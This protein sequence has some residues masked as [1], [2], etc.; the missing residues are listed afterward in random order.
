[1]RV[2]LLTGLALLAA[3]CTQQGDP[4][5]GDVAGGPTPA[6]T[7]STA[8]DSPMPTSFAATAWL[9]EADDGARYTTF[10]D[11]DGTYR[12]LRNGDPWQTGSWTYN[13]AGDGRLCFTPD[14]KNGVQRCWLPDSM[15]G[16][17]MD[18]IGGTDSRRVELQPVDYTPPPEAKHKKRG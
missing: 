10:L 11:A 5:S 17:A 4:T 18:V 8:T 12:D 2:P 15:N 7:S 3:A 14:A 1:M 13:D 9:S 6:A 16:E